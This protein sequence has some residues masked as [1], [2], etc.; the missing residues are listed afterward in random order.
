MKKNILITGGAGYIGYQ[1]VKQLL[2]RKDVFVTVLDSFI[3][4]SD[5]LIEFRKNKNLNVIKGDICNI[6]DMVKVVKNADIVVALAAIVGDPACALDEEQTYSSNY[7]STALLIQLCNY[8]KVKR[9]IFASSC[10]VYGASDN[11]LN[12]G[13]K[14]NPLSLYAKTRVMSEELIQKNINQNLEWIILRFGTVFGRSK[15]M[16]FDLVVNFLTANSFFTKKIDILGKDQWRPLV[17][18]RDVANSLFLS[19]FADKSIVSKEIFNVG[20]NKLNVQI[21]D[22]AKK[23]GSKIKKI[24][25][26]YKQIPSSDRRNYRVSFDKIRTIL[27]FEAKYS[28]ED[29]INEIIL[30]LSKNKINYLDDKYYNVKYLFKLFKK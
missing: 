10:S 22:I 6:Y 28:I 19:I 4:E 9:L 2:K 25:I 13:S 27:K 23:I 17:H 18:V 30:F 15:R 20:D 21:K 29:G 12:E 7:H 14:L 8:Y 16:R 1:L 26:N 11:L 5:S 24:R 3:Y